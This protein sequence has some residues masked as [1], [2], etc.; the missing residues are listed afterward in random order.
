MNMPQPTTRT[1]RSLLA[2]AL[3]IIPTAAM[4]ADAA[5]P[6]PSEHSAPPQAQTAPANEPSFDLDFPGGSVTELLQAI[7]KASGHMPNVVLGEG[8]DRVKIPPVW[9]RRITTAMLFASLQQ[10]RFGVWTPISNPSMATWTLTYE[11]APYRPTQMVHAFNIQPLLANRDIKDIVAAVQ[12][13][14][15]M[16][17]DDEGVTAQ[18][19][20][21]KETQLLI[22]SGTG[23][24]I[25]VVEQVLHELG[26]Q[27]PAAA[28]PKPDSPVAKP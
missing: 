16:K 24:Q 17:K 12:V 14:L 6:V 4:A 11:N 13:T 21:H 3:L 15:E 28:K 22:V 5:A 27:P 9:V 20:Y 7:E 19:K 23:S 10:A 1:V 26:P 8:A 25:S 18:F 2:T